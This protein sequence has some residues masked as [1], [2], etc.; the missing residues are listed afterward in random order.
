MYYLKAIR[1]G[2]YPRSRALQHFQSCIP[3]LAL[4]VLLFLSVIGL[5][6]VAIFGEDTSA[7]GTQTG[8]GD[9]AKQLSFVLVFVVIAAHTAVTGGLRQLLQVPLPFCVLLGWC[10]ISLLWAINPD[11]ALRRVMLTTMVMLSLTYAVRGL[12]AR[13]VIGLI[14][15]CFA[16]ILVAD[17]V[18]IALLDFAVQQPTEVAKELA[19]DWRGLHN[20]KNEAGAFCAICCILF[21]HAS[22]QMRSF[23]C[24]PLLLIAAAVFLFMTKSKTSGGFVLVAMAI[25]AMTSLCYNNPVFRKVVLSALAI[26]AL[27]AISLVD[28]YY[29]SL[30]AIFD[31]PAAFTGRSQ[32]W[33][34]LVDYISDHPLLG[35]GYGSFWS[36]GDASPIFV[37]GSGWLTKI[38]Q[39]HN[40]YLELAVQTGLIGLA[41]ALAVLVARPLI[42][43][44][45]APLHR[46]TSRW[47]IC[48]ILAFGCLHDLLE[49][50]LLDRANLTWVIMVIM[51][52]LLADARIRARAATSRFM[53]LPGRQLD[54]LRHRPSRRPS[55]PA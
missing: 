50:S 18:S 34:I 14:I 35:S 42:L 7:V 15:G 36:V 41:L 8:D 30:F 29:D 47:L 2:S 19:G 52:C 21:L 43:L 10:W 16:V 54:A 48:S 3:K 20:H 24:G 38:F 39:A 4:V 23:F 40:G 9:V 32:I 44:F 46:Q 31:D 33:P 22:Y 11:V 13:T 49:S 27:L 5:S 55:V 45:S 37:Y 1:T 51:Y 26:G 6:P 25:G 12:P 17:W 53:G 28:I